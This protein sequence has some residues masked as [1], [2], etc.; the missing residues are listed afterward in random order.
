MRHVKLDDACSVQAGGTPKRSEPLFWVDGSIPWVRISDIKGLHVGSTEEHITDIGLQNSSAK[1]FEVDT[2]LYS[3]FAS[4]GVS[5]IL[6][7][8]AATNQAIAGIKIR[9]Q[10][11]AILNR[12]Y[13]YYY[14]Q[15]ITPYF[16]S[17]ARGAT[18][19][20][21]NLSMLRSLD[22]PIPSVDYQETIVAQ[23]NRTESYLGSCKTLL[24]KFDELVKSR[25]TRTE[26]AA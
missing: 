2:I 10:Y 11:A 17:R 12:D 20:N 1:L 24:V 23:L 4:I 3:I 25:F 13:L 21:I 8:P 5:G 26:V 19:N 14:L 15:S 16:Q 7:T 22:V 6:D 9:K 18:Q